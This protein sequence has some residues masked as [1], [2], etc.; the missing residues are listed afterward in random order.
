MSPGRSL[1]V[2]FAMIHTSRYAAF[3]AF[4]IAS[5]ACDARSR[6]ADV[7]AGSE[8][9]DDRGILYAEHRIA[10]IR[11]VETIVGG[12]ASLG[13]RLPV[14]VSIHGRGD[15]VRLPPG[16]YPGVTSPVRLIMPEAPDAFHE[17]FTWSPVSVTEGR[18]RELAAALARNAERIA[19][20]LEWVEEERD[21][22]GKPI[23]TGFSQ[24]GM[25][26][27]TLAARYPDRIGQSVPI[28]GFLPAALVPR[29]APGGALPE[30]HA[31]H[32]TDDPV[33]RIGPTRRSVRR[34]RSIGYPVELAEVEGVR[35]IYTDALHAAVDPRIA[36][37]I[38]AERT[39]DEGSLLDEILP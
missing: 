6:G 37:A 24:G 7:T 35:H 16:R 9:R 12:E 11:V 5:I 28:A 30:I 39:R 34:L 3:A 26:S 38:T 1:P 32:G 13:D 36:A 15:R 17:G 22:V 14:I 2:P 18:T 31:I 21:V 4:V 23:V 33:V 20:V 29:H 19:R 27:F 8:Q 25:L 10:G